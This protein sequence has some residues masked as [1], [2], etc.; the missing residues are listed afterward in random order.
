MTARG[1]RARGMKWRGPF[2]A[3][4]LACCA[5]ATAWAERI[6]RFE[7]DVLLSASDTFA[8]EERIAYDFGDVKRHGIERWIPV[9]YGRGQSADYRIEI[10]VQQVTDG[11]GAPLRVQERREG[12]NLVLRIGDPDTVVTG[13]RE[14]RIRYTVRRGIL[15]LEPHDEIYW[16][17]T[18][19]EWEVPIESARAR[20]R[21]PDG[22]DAAKL[23]ALCFTGPQGA[24]QSDC[25]I[26]RTDG[27]L[28]FVAKRGLG[29]REG[30]TLVA[31]LP[32]GVLP[33]PS[34][35]ARTIDRATDFASPWLLLPVATLAGMFALWRTLGRDPGAGNESV[36]ARYDPP[37]GL[38]PAEVGTV[39]DESA[40][41]SDL[42]A[43]IV[44]LAVHGFLRIEEVETKSFLFLTNRDYVLVKLREPEGRKAHERELMTALFGGADR[45]KVSDLRNTFYVHLPEIQ[46]ALYGEL[47]GREGGCFATD[48]ERTRRGWL[49][50]GIVISVAGFFLSSPP[51]LRIAGISCAVSGLIVLAF[52]RSMP[53]RTR[54][55]RQALQ[56][57]LGLR[58]FLS[59]VEA[60]RLQR[61]G[62]R[63]RERFEAILPY[64]IVLGCADAWANA[65][66]DIYTQPPAWFGSP[67]YDREFTPRLLVH[68]MGQSLTTIGRAMTSAP[69][70]AGSG[71]S[72][73][74]G[75]GSSGGGFGGGGGK[76]W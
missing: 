28:S 3:L 11:S 32:K 29:A 25:S 14:Y 70:S 52:A 20:L 48:P 37:A 45:V 35:A 8:V 57:I 1:A 22:V 13:A 60:D 12:R 51:E 23:E 9:A 44:D 31:A 53:R 64:A 36:A 55:G 47:T 65:F 30:L 17:A 6:L 71:I 69:R 56:E 63:T 49:N 19:T 41:L 54:K 15:Y 4:A 59:R 46:K 58:E 67:R 62:V 73:F 75:G 72:G 68:H 50:A 5:P 27:S 24:V 7:T 38:S 43:T 34:P 42:T 26:E 66:A 74:G 21:L 16:N 61:E 2:L 18:G 33:V 10:S 76:S 39:L 40:D